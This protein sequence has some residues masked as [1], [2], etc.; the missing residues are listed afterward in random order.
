M[1]AIGHEGERTIYGPYHIVGF[2]VMD[3]L[4]FFMLRREVKGGV[5]ISGVSDI[6]EV[7]IGGLRAVEVVIKKSDF[8]ALSLDELC[9]VTFVGYR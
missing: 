1:R 5:G 9:N 2:E 4:S 7:S 8:M 6:T 3:L